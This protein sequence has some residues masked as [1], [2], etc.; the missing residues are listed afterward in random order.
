MFS[1][2][3]PLNFNEIKPAD[4]AIQRVNILIKITSVNAIEISMPCRLKNP[5][6][7]PSTTPIPNGRKEN[8]PKTIELVYVVMTVINSIW[9]IPKDN[10]TK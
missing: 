1:E 4:T 6:R 2:K 7:L 5:A 10:K 8:T 9:F 3:P